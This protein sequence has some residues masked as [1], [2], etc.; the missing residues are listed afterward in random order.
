MYIFILNLRWLYLI[1]RKKNPKKT[2]DQKP[3]LTCFLGAGGG[4]AQ[5]LS[6]HVLGCWTQT[7]SGCEVTFQVFLSLTFALLSK[8][9]HV[10]TYRQCQNSQPSTV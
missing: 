1:L 8:E 9:Y 3:C 6:S 4:F 2:T 10:C 5:D 7:I